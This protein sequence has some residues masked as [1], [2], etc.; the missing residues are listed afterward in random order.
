MI[1][2]IVTKDVAYCIFTGS[3]YKKKY[4]RCGVQ[5]EY[6]ETVKMILVLTSVYSTCTYN[7][8]CSSN[9]SCKWCTAEENSV[10]VILW[11][12]DFLTQMVLL[13]QVR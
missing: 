4:H 5:Q 9:T 8:V 11:S 12:N 1:P 2:F 7:P 3:S 6:E 13:Y 10:P